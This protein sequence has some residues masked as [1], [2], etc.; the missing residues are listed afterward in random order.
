[1]CDV[2]LPPGVNPT[3]VKYVY[4]NISILPLVFDRTTLF[5]VLESWPL[6]MVFAKSSSRLGKG[7][8]NLGF[9]GKASS[10]T[11]YNVIRNACT[12]NISHCSDV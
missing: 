4:H 12:L 3:A 8:I 1:M 5:L 11:K 9:R 6:N 10:P 7:L 2:L